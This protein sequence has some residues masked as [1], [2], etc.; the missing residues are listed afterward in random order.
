M[1]QIKIGKFIS[2]CRKNKKLTQEQ[3]AEKLNISVNAVSKWERGL[4]LP[5]YSNIKFG[6]IVDDNLKYSQIYVAGEGNI[7]GNVDINK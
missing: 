6:Y 5:D 1:D 3:M 7:K 4:N 2:L